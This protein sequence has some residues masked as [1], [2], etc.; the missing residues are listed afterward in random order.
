MTRTRP[1]TPGY[2]RLQV[3]AAGAMASCASVLRLGG[4][5]SVEDPAGLVRRQPWAGVVYR[6]LDL[7][8]L[9]LAISESIVESHGGRIWANGNGGRGS[10]FDFALPAIAAGS[11]ASYA[12]E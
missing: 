2:T 3:V 6:D 12:E 4:K 10:T 11:E 8:V 7:A 9:R 1:R 5:E